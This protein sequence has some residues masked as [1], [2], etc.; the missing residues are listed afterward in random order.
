[1]I[2]IGAAITG[3][4]HLNTHIGDHLGGGDPRATTGHDI[5]IF[6]GLELHRIRVGYDEILAP[7]KAR[8]NLGIETGSYR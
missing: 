5:G 2:G 6:S 7:A 3:E 1:L 8:V 4:H